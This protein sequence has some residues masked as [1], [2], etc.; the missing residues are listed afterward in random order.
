MVVELDSP[1]NA[2]I[3]ERLRIPALSMAVKYN[4]GDLPNAHMSQIITDYWDGNAFEIDA[5]D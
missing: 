3:G 4:S 2:A 1:V 5:H